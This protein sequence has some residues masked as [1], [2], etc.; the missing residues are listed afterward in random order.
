MAQRLGFRVVRA[1]RQNP[2]SA[3]RTAV[4][5]DPS[6]PQGSVAGSTE[7]ELRAAGAAAGIPAGRGKIVFQGRV[8]E[9]SSCSNPEDF[10]SLATG[11]STYG[12]PV[13]AGLNLDGKTGARDFAGA[14]G[15]KGIDNQLWRVVGCTKAFRENSD[16]AYARKTFIS[17]LRPTLITLEGVDD[18][19]NDPDVTVLVR[20]SS[21]ALT[22]DGRGQILA[23]ATFTV[24]PDPR[25]QARG[26]GRIVNGELITEPFDVTIA[27][28]EQIIDAPREIRGARIRA[29]LREDGH[30]DGGIYGYYSIASYWESVAQM[31]QVGADAN[32]ISCPAVRKAL[33]AFADGYRDPKTKRFT[34]ISSA[35]DFYGTKAF[36]VTPAEVAATGSTP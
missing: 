8:F 2:S 12:G 10:P 15:E 36:A 20:T 30:I 25:F 35:L 32:A 9:Y 5:G 21:D 16:P 29:R 33:E 17:A 34:A 31:T 3:P 24:D 14:N 18:L 19:G 7:Q 23:R 26:K 6:K 22:R 27:Y 4:A 28:K 11:A 1:G 13:A